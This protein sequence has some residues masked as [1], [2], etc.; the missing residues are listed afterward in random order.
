MSQQLTINPNTIFDLNGHPVPLGTATFFLTG[1]TTPVT[2]YLN[3]ALS[4][5]ATQ[6][7]EADAAGRIPQLFAASGQILK[8]VIKDDSGA[9]LYTLDPMVLTQV[10]AS[11]ADAITFTP[12]TNNPATNVQTAIT[13]LQEQV[14][15]LDAV[16]VSYTNAAFP[17]LT[18]VDSVLDLAAANAGKT[19]TTEDLNTLN[20]SGRYLQQNPTLVSLARNYPYAASA[21]K[22]YISV[23]VQTF[24]HGGIR[25]TLNDGF[26][27]YTRSFGLDPS[28]LIGASAWTA[29]IETV[30]TD[31]FG[32]WSYSWHPYNKTSL[33]DTTSTGIFYNSATDGIVASF[34]TPLMV[35]GYEYMVRGDSISPSATT[36]MRYEIRRETD[37]V[38]N[39]AVVFSGSVTAAQFIDFEVVLPSARRSTTLHVMDYWAGLLAG[40]NSAALI[41]R[42]SVQNNFAVSQKI[43]VVRFSWATGN[44]DNGVMRLLRRRVS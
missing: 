16:A 40:A 15:D 10:T 33:A 4:T 6:P 39:P 26:A 11:T 5:V 21:N 44:I 24:A 22:G 31:L 27:T 8:A 17:T 1:T 25:Q 36:T 29:W 42:V 35:D 23:D 19:I 38:F 3:S 18:T 2:V 14:D 34:T 7:V 43:D 13:N 30:D 28:V 12:I 9:T 37:A 20:V 32:P 41:S